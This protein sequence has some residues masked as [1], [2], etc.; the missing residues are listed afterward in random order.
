MATENTSYFKLGANA[1][2]FYCPAS[3]LKLVTGHPG[4]TQKKLS[5][6][7]MTAVGNGHIV[8]IEEAEYEELK[9]KNA[10]KEEAPAATKEKVEETDPSK[11]NM[12]QLDKYAKELLEDES[13]VEYSA[14]TT[15]KDKKAYIAEAEAE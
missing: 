2:A 1:S 14:L 4:K 5:K 15:L 3:G 10:S 6:K 11:M 8:K 12:K 7:V 9:A 13:F